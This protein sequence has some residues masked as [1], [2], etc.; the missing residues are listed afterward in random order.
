MMYLTSSL[1]LSLRSVQEDE[2]RIG[3]CLGKISVEFALGE[4][5]R[6]IEEG[7]E[8]PRGRQT[9]SNRADDSEFLAG[10]ISNST[11]GRCMDSV[12]LEGSATIELLGQLG[13][14]GVAMGS[15]FAFY[16]ARA[17]GK[18]IEAYSKDIQD[19]A[20][21][22]THGKANKGEPLMDTRDLH[23]HDYRLRMTFCV[24]GSLMGEDKAASDAWNS[25]GAQAEVYSLRWE[26]NS[27]R[28]LATCLEMISD[29][30]G[31]MEAKQ[32]FTKN[33]SE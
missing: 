17:T 24:N 19:F 1:N 11:L 20:L 7:A 18:T 2:V 29:S 15:L 26:T 13:D 28:S 33:S 6:R 16:G 21:I 14:N 27:L 22:P 31:W 12:I 5:A 32:Y 9:G 10:P 3:R 8:M 25:I 4:M 23:P 30:R